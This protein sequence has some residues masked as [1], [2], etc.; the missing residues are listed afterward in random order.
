MRN[1]LVETLIGAVVL[2]VAGAFLFVSYTTAGIRTDSGYEFDVL[3]NRIDGVT[4]GTDVRIAGIKV[5]SVSAMRLDTVTFDAVATLQVFDDVEIPDDS[6]FRVK[7]D[8]LLGDTFIGVQI[9]GSEITIAAGDTIFDGKGPL[10]LFELVAQFAL[11]SGG[12]ANQ[13]V[14]SSE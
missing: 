4:I 13:P 6:S 2:A 11:G 5:G 14:A 1:T 8:G 9:G 3:F 12:D 7:T 10:D